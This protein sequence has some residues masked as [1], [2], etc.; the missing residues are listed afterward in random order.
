MFIVHLR[1]K[2]GEIFSFD[3]ISLSPETTEKK[4]REA[5]V[6]AYGY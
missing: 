5:K 4:T 3:K 2:S 6:D 1:A